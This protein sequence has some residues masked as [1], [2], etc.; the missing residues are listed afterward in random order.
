MASRRLASSSSLIDVFNVLGQSLPPMG[1]L[2]VLYTVGSEIQT[3]ISSVVICNQ[4]ANQGK[5]RISI[6]VAGDVDD[7][8]QYLCYDTVVNPNDSTIWTS[9]LTMGPDDELRVQSNNGQIAFSCY[10][11]EITGTT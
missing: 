5:Y 7:L 11:D 2:T 10:G 6:A 1:V 9:G 3:V 4:S 8:S